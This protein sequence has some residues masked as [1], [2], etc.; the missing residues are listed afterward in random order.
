MEVKKYKKWENL[1]TTADNKERGVVSFNKLNT[2]WFNT[3]TLCNLSCDN[4]YIE[5][6][7]SND[8]LVYLTLDDVKLYTDEIREN[9]WKLESF[10]I[11]GGEPFLNP[12]IIEILR[13][14]L[15]LNIPVLVLTNAHKVIKRWEKH[16]LELKEEFGDLLRL[17]ISLDH[18]TKEVHEGERGQNTFATTIKSMKWLHLNDFHISIAGRSLFEENEKTARDGYQALLDKNQFNL[19]LSPDSLVIFPEMNATEDVPEITTDCWNILK[20]SPND[21]MCAT[22]RMIVKRKNESKPK[23]L[24]CTL[25]A[26][27]KDFELGHTL[28]ESFRDIHLNHPYCSK[29]CVLGGASCSSTN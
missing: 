18:Y 24:S 7:P 6:S 16:L 5:S 2:L 17:R 8:R 13:E 22:Q 11:T 1:Y 23:V 26:Y 3:G 12:H 25:I 20:V 29:F 28:K 21:Q 15:S 10:G 27:N 14:C 9:N 4:C 19:E